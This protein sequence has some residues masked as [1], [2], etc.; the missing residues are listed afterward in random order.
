MELSQVTAKGKKKSKSA[1]DA[2]S[3]V[4]PKLSAAPAVNRDELAN[5]VKDGVSSPSADNEGFGEEVCLYYLDCI[6]YQESSVP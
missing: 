4:D 2:L 1:H 5:D 6:S 3:D